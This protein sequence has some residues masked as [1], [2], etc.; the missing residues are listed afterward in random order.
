MYSYGIPALQSTPV[1]Q[2]ENLPPPF[3]PFAEN[4]PFKE[5]DGSGSQAHPK[6]VELLMEEFFIFLL[7]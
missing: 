6:K 2:S 5:M 3:L 7:E 1:F 4:L